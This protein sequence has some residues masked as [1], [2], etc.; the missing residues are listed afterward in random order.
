MQFPG[1]LLDW[2][3]PCPFLWNHRHEV[4]WFQS[5]DIHAKIIIKSCHQITLVTVF[6]LCC[7]LV[8]AS[9]AWWQKL[10]DLGGV[11][12]PRPSGSLTPELKLSFLTSSWL[13]LLI[14][15]N[16]KDIHTHYSLPHTDSVICT[17]HFL[18]FGILFCL[19]LF[20]IYMSTMYNL[21][22]H[23]SLVQSCLS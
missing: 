8:S 15:Y 17:Q 1:E 20:G 18:C 2:Q 5:H 3:V 16:Q 9:A 23:S 13:H 11:S 22:A 10:R 21:F 19:V 4:M 6:S 12:S 7:H 14:T